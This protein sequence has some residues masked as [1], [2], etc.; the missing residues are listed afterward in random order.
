[1][2][3]GRVLG[4]R[5]APEVGARLAQEATERFVSSRAARNTVQASQ[6]A[7]GGG[8]KGV[9]GLLRKLFGQPEQPVMAELAEPAADAPRSFSAEAAK[10]DNFIRLLS[11][12]ATPQQVQAEAAKRHNMAAAAQ[13]LAGSPQARATVNPQATAQ[14]AARGPAAGFAQQAREFVSRQMGGAGEDAAR[15]QTPRSFSSMAADSANFARLL[16]GAKT[17]DE[18]RAEDPLR[19]QQQRAERDEATKKTIV[20]LGLLAGGAGGAAAAL[21]KTPEAI[22][23]F[24]RRMLQGQEELRKFNGQINNAFARLERE[25][26]LRQ[27][28]LANATSGSTEL[29]ADA[30][31]D[32]SSDTQ[33]LVQAS[34]TIINLLGTIAARGGQVLTWL[35]K[36]NPQVAQVLKLLGLI[37]GWLSREERKAAPWPK[38]LDDLAEG[39]YSGTMRDRKTPRPPKDDDEE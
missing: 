17:P 22:E 12:Q 30:L 14:P 28:E 4:R 36:L 16:S 26:L 34:V 37:E 2:V 24:V 8:G 9:A 5:A 20:A 19:L 39:V 33:E 7:S 27:R 10:P 23:G 11:G 35:I 25:D 1:M 13:S 38:F 18:V 6:P 21:L 3:L 29:L 31:N 15:E 32:L